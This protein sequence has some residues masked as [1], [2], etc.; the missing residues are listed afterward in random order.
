MKRHLRFASLGAALLLAAC[1]TSEGQLQPGFRLPSK[2]GYSY[3]SWGKPNVSR[4]QYD[5][6][7][8]D[9][10][11]EGASVAVDPQALEDFAFALDPGDAVDLARIRNVEMS[12]ERA[13]I[14]ERR[15]AIEGCLWRRGFVK[16]GLTPDQLATLET[17]DQGTPE[18]REYLYGLGSDPMVLA[19]QA[20][21]ELRPEQ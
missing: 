13:V 1:A 17:L 14:R 19:A 16:F 7:S 3:F 4:S 20:L 9:C 8:V 18:R 5:D 12:R 10:V 2:T 6:A 21:P 11:I 15:E